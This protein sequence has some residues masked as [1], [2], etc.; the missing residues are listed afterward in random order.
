MPDPMCIDPS[1]L[2][3]YLGDIA[4]IDQALYTEDH[5]N[6]TDTLDLSNMPDAYEGNRY[7]RPVIHHAPMSKTD[8]DDTETYI[9]Y[10]EDQITILQ[11]SNSSD[12]ADEA[13]IKQFYRDW[14]AHIDE[15][16]G[17]LTEGK[18]VVLEPKYLQLGDHVREVLARNIQMSE[19]SE[20]AFSGGTTAI[21]DKASD[22]LSDGFELGEWLDQAWTDTL[23]PLDPVVIDSEAGMLANSN[24]D[25]RDTA[26]DLTPR[27][28]HKN[29]QV[30]GLRSKPTLTIGY[31]QHRLQAL[32]DTYLN[33]TR[34]QSGKTEQPEF[35]GRK[36]DSIETEREMIKSEMKRLQ[37]FI[38][39]RREQNRESSRSKRQRDRRG[40]SGRRKK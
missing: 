36:N 18:K 10:L 3:G 40:L 13:E 30:I 22:L 9:K 1:L 25:R 8:T 26:S 24:T 2:S 28:G 5:S 23:I 17:Y 21:T 14:K 7:D 31:C 27:D 6:H 37:A 38:K 16:Q 29:P 19:P 35:E 39:R 20:W 34:A 4:D 12:E 32:T 33:L 15:E 11:R